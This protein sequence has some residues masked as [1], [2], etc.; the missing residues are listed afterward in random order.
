M[1][2]Q[3]ADE[4]TAAVLRGEHPIGST[5][6]AEPVLAEVYG[7]S[8]VTVNRAVALL[9]QAGLVEVRRGVGTVVVADRPAVMVRLPAEVLD[10]AGEDVEAWVVR[11]CEQRLDW[12]R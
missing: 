1:H 6:P 11:A 5:L 10:A 9:R 7:V 3:I 12:E 2:A 4:L 8:R